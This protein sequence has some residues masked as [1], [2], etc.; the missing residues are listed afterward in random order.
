M[1]FGI[2][3]CRFERPVNECELSKLSNNKE[4]TLKIGMARLINPLEVL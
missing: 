4:I 1:G 2:G 3:F